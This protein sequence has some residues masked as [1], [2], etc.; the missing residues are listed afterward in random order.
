MSRKLLNLLLALSLVMFVGCGSD[1]DDSDP[2]P[3]PQLEEDTGGENNTN[4]DRNTDDAANVRDFDTRLDPNLAVSGERCQGGE[5]LE[6]ALNSDEVCKRDEWLISV[7]NVNTC[8][9]GGAC[10]EEGVI[11]FIAKLDRSETRTSE[12]FHFYRIDPESP[13]S[14]GQRAVINDVWVRANKQTGEATVIRRN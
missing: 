10:T 8:T 4:D 1:D 2:S 12:Q 11:P 5:T 6:P 3:P 7:D 14:A 13:V 9:P